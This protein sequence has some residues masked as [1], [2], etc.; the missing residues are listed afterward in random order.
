MKS[1][2]ELRS[3]RIVI[4]GGGAAGALLALHVL[5]T[6]SRTPR[7]P[8]ALS[9]VEPRVN[10]AEGVAYSTTDPQH[11][12]NVP[13]AGMSAFSADAE[14]FVRWANAQPG[15]FVVRHRF[16]SYLR[17]RLAAQTNDISQFTHVR[18]TVQHIAVTAGQAATSA[19]FIVTLDTG[20][21]LQADAVVLAL[22]NAP[23]VQPSWLNT[24]DPTRVI[25]DPWAPGAL[26][27]IP[28]GSHALLI[29]TG[30]T[31]VDV[32]LSLTQRNI[33]V[34]A[35]SRSGMLP[36]SHVT[37]AESPT[38][39]N[40]F[41]SP[42]QVSRWIR[43][44]TD[45]RAA[46]AALRPHTQHIWQSFS[47]GQQASFLRHAQ[48]HWDVHRHRMAPQVATR[49]NSL[50]ESGQITLAVDS[51]EDVARLTDADFVVLCTGPDD[52]AYARSPL[53]AS[54]IAQKFTAVGPH[55]MGIAT[56]RTTGAVLN[57]DSRI[58]PGLFA[59]GTLR[60]G[61]L[62]ESTAIPELRT[63]AEQLAQ[64]LLTQDFTNASTS[65]HEQQSLAT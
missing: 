45:W 38:P 28:D 50:L 54:L 23:P 35:T 12:L 44:Q 24:I 18:A 46:I 32:A 42:S 36:K 26:Q 29:G 21:V 58:T 64:V 13:A 11:M 60:R 39:P 53:L 31:F 51:P 7:R 16:G 43:S 49:L 6:A 40:H 25:V 1:A 47:S 2:D 56:D 9:I 33:R 15:D 57:K 10:L 61:T 5:R 8:V 37:I 22:G 34:T 41:A 48:R 19:T 14:D 4:V 65:S 27:V 63:Q 17:E 59:I 20:G 62:W 52:T 3:Q 30:L 55:A